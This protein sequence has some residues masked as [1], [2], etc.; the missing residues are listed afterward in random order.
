VAVDVN[1]VVVGAPFD[2]IAIKSNQ[3]SAYVFGRKITTA[4]WLRL[5][6]TPGMVPHE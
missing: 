6:L 1:T 4:G 5:I 2:D 3:G